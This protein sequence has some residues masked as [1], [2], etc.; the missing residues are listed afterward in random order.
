[1]HAQYE[2]KSHVPACTSY[3]R[4]TQ[5]RLVAGNPMAQ[6]CRADFR[7]PRLAGLRLRGDSS[8]APACL[9]TVNGQL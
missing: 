7:A 6:P 2:V 5:L 8:K 3:V 1:M 9:C 4:E